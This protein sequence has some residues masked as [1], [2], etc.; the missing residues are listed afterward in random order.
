MDEPT[1]RDRFKRAAQACARCRKAKRRCD[2]ALPV[3]TLC[4]RLRKECDY[5]DNSPGLPNADEFA[6]LRDKVGE[7]EAKLEISMTGSSGIYTPDGASP[8]SLPHLHAQGLLSKP[9]FP[10]GFFLDNEVYGKEPI[11]RPFVTIPQHMWT[12]LGTTANIKAMIEAYFDTVHTW[13]PIV[14]KKRL[15]LNLANPNLE[16]T[17]DLA[18]LLLSMKNILTEPGSILGGGSVCSDVYWRT[19]GFASVVEHSGLL[20]LHLLQSIVLLSAFEIGQGL[21]PAAYLTTGH[22]ARLGHALGFHDRKE[23]PQMLRRPG[24]WAEIEETTR[25]W[26][27]VMLLDRYVSLGSSGHPLATEDPSRADVLPADDS[28]W[29][30]GEMISSE[31]LYVS[32]KTSLPAS[33]FQRT[34]QATHVI[35]RYLRHRDDKLLEP[36]DRFNEACQLLRTMH[37]LAALMPE[38]AEKRPEQYATPIALCYTALIHLCD[39]YACTATNHGERTVE[40]VD[41][42]TLTIA[43]MKQAAA[44]VC[45]L[46]QSI[47]TAMYRNFE[48]TSPLIADALYQGAATYAWLVHE[49]GEIANVRAYWQICDVLRAME[50]RWAC[51]SEYLKLL[52]KTKKDLYGDNQNLMT[53]MS[54]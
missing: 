12:L 27:A 39:P 24:A 13:L 46:S 11:P 2:K 6:T 25:T 50:P 28:S 43:G 22:A 35:G 15:S 53:Q 5:S 26:Y 3:C 7:L 48:A 30:I 42:Q 19:K 18:L 49:T 4:S 34:C 14:S 52:D 1:G 32:S 54:H 38:E 44:D 37:A 40:E 9:S 36:K 31:P 23:A 16:P 8:E 41:L 10:T 29:D 45:R 17:A 21:F 47:R 51:A 33:W 20:T